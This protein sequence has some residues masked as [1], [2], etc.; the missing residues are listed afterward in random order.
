MAVLGSCRG[1]ASLAGHS[2]SPPILLAMVEAFY[3]HTA[4]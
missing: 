2:P 1:T 3:R 4:L